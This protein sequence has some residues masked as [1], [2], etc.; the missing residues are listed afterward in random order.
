MDKG[1]Q[2]SFMIEQTFKDHESILKSLESGQSLVSILCSPAGVY[3]QILD[4]LSQ[5]LPLK[6]A[7]QCASSLEKAGKRKAMRFLAKMAY[8]ISLFIFSYLM[9]TFFESSI[10]PS[11]QSF[12]Q[13]ENFLGIQLIKWFLSFWL[14]LGCI[15][16]V[17]LLILNC[18]KELRVYAVSNLFNKIPIFKAMMTWQFSCALSACLGHGISTERTLKTLCLIQDH[19]Y[20]QY[21]AQSLQEQL[22]QGCTI[23]ESLQNIG[24]DETFLHYYLIG[25][26]SNNLQAM[27]DLY[28]RKTEKRIDL[29]IKKISIWIQVLSYFS[30]GAVVLIVYQVMLLPMEL[31]NTF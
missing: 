29:A 26:R 23:V 7:I 8:P 27:L 11:M 18:S 14:I 28:Q 20:I 22:K 21:Y 17:L 13:A 1:L 16:I 10:L 3:F 15:G 9:V 4:A 31:L 6:E 24:V 2:T 5:I 12:T 30:V 25:S 19:S